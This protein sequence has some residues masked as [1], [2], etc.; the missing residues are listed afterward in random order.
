MAAE[1]RA[2]LTPAGAI[3]PGSPRSRRCRRQLGCRAGQA[4]ERWASGPTPARSPAG[5]PRQA[6]WSGSPGPRPS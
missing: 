2:G 6:A 3:P 5:C 1:A 4:S